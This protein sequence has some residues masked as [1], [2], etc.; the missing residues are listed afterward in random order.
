MVSDTGT[1]GTAPPDSA[2]ARPNR[3]NRSAEA[4]GR[5]AS[6]TATRSSASGEYLASNSLTA[7]HV[8][9]VREDPA[10]ARAQGMSR[11]R[12]KSRSRFCS[13]WP[14]VS[15]HVSG[16]VRIRLDG[17]KP[18]LESRVMNSSR[19][20]VNNR[21]P[22][23]GRNCLGTLSESAAR[24]PCPPASRIRCR[25]RATIS[26]PSC[27]APGRFQGQGHRFLDA[28]DGHQFHPLFFPPRG[29]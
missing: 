28:G 4:N 22:T 27:L 16:T 10:E 23:T 1:P 14:A 17:R 21:P 13:A 15:R 11:S 2:A 20:T 19:L 5:A 26:A 25:L 9:A 8:E 24:N 6:C 7:F 18:E 3:S 29:L 12:S